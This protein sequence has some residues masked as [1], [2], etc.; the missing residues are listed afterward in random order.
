MSGLHYPATFRSIGQSWARPLRA[1]L[2]AL[3]LALGSGA[4][5][6]VSP[7]VAST[8]P[9][10]VSF[11]TATSYATTGH[12][13]DAVAIAMWKHR[14]YVVA[15]NRVEGN[16]SVF[17]GRR[18]VLDAPVTYGLGSCQFPVSLAVGDLN[19]DG[20]PD[21]AVG[22][23]SD[24]NTVFPGGIAIV[25]GRDVGG[26]LGFGP[27]TNLRCP[28]QTQPVPAGGA[29][30]FVYTV[31]LA[32][33]RGNHHLDLI[34]TNSGVANSSF[35]A[36]AGI[37]SVWLNRGDGSFSDE[38]LN[39]PVGDPGS[40]A[41]IGAFFPRGL[42]IADLTGSGHLDL[43]V[44]NGGT[45]T[46][47]IL[48]GDG[49]G[50]FGPATKLGL[51]GA[52]YPAPVALADLT[53]NGRPDLIVGDLKPGPTGSA[54]VSVFLNEGNGKFG[55]PTNYAL[56]EFAQPQGMAVGDLNGDGQSDLAVADSQGQI[57]VLVGDGRGGFGAP[58]LLAAGNDPQGVSL[59][60]LSRDDNWPDLVVA[61]YGSNSVSVLVN[62]TRRPD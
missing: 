48:Q 45:N 39:F 7:A 41:G 36:V 8:P 31:K 11:A 49:T 37:V 27:A 12:G 47:A 54:N 5:A 44:A 2:A 52:T 32:D 56:G 6:Q 10:T 26:D 38:P 17:T 29:C 40:T 21:L 60:H 28:D 24:S 42:A 43:V 18:G 59:A 16:I 19:G 3:A 35:G 57:G 14:S 22:C 23:G 50:H 53:G 61:N 51:N 1:L 33:V 46:V 30:N 58:T 13:T 20:I 62:V 55:T 25:P 34:A 15:L 4:I 9:R